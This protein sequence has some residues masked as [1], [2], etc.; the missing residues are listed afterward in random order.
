MTES[1]FCKL[2]IAMLLPLLLILGSCATPD[3]AATFASKAGAEQRITLPG[4]GLT[5]SG[6]LF[7]PA[8]ARRARHPAIVLL[9]GCSGMLDARGRLSS[10]QRAWAERFA[11]TQGRVVDARSVSSQA[12]GA[13]L[14]DNTRQKIERAA[15]GVQALTWW[16]ANPEFRR[17]GR[18]PITDP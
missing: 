12:L 18:A 16:F 15:S 1:T 5:L 10:N 7:P 8:G 2:G 14:S 17:R 11:Q 6:V 3:R 4:P 9:H 13:D